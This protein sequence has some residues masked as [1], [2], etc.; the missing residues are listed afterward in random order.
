[1]FQETDL[2]EDEWDKLRSWGFFRFVHPTRHGLLKLREHLG[3][4]RCLQPFH[5]LSRRAPAALLTHQVLGDTMPQSSHHGPR[6][7]GCALWTDVGRQL[8]VAEPSP[9]SQPTFP[10]TVKFN[11]LS[12]YNFSPVF[13]KQVSLRLKC[14]T[15]EVFLELIPPHHKPKRTGIYKQERC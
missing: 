6:R 9:S 2:S 7:M 13:N 8:C 11:N 12:Q 10:Q 1:M 14:C 15:A 3:D 5:A 4:A